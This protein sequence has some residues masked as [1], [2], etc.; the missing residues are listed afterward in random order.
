MVPENT[1][2]TLTR[3]SKQ[4]LSNSYSFIMNKDI[5]YKTIYKAENLKLNKCKISLKLLKLDSIRVQKIICLIMEI[6]YESY[7]Y[8]IRPNFN[9]IFKTHNL[10][11][12]SELK[13]F[14]V[15][16]I[17]TDSCL[18]INSLQFCN[19]LNKQFSNNLFINLIYKLL[20]HEIWQYNQF[21]QFNKDILNK[22]T[23]FSIF[24]NI[25]FNE[26]DNWV[27]YK[28]HQL[29]QVLTCPYAITYEQLL[30]QTNKKTKQIQKLNKTA[31]KYKIIQKKL[32]SLEQK[33]IKIIK[34]YKQQIQ[35]KYFRY[36]NDW[37]IGMKGELFLI[38]T[39]KIE[40]NYFLLIYLKQTLNSIKLTTINVS[41][42]EIQFMGYQIYSLNNRKI[43][44]YKPY[45]DKMSCQKNFR[46]EFHIPT[47]F[48]FRK[49]EKEGYI[50][51]LTTCYQSISKIHCIQLENII[52]LKHFTQIWR[53]LLNHYSECNNLSKLQLIHYNLYLS[54]I[55]TL[56]DRHCVNIKIL[57]A[58][59]GKTFIVFKNGMAINFPYKI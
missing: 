35:I 17:I 26:L 19:I 20:R 59:Y 23:I 6:T 11:D 29:T 1:E 37:I 9:P 3:F 15:E 38:E 10:F 36:L 51:K 54:F 43:N 56:K 18:Q 42:N 31:K 52:I 4:K 16:K 45:F 48:I 21:D 55:M 40:I 50:K 44:N 14:W 7:F 58:K 32:I 46:I 41:R 53:G 24:T 2:I 8:K 34:T 49:M 28:T 25:Y 13:N 5:Q 22:K 12:C 39:L 57:F 33:K 47:G 30:Y 27:G